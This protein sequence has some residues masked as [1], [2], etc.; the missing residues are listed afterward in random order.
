[1]LGT[2]FAFRKEAYKCL[3]AHSKDTVAAASLAACCQT[4]VSILPKTESCVKHEWP[5]GTR[6]LS[7]DCGLNDS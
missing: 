7:S 3:A 1:M 2:R 4:P 5:V 6:P